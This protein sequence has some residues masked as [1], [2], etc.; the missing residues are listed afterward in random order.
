M[1]K[2]RRLKRE[3][4]RRREIE[5]IKRRKIGYYFHIHINLNLYSMLQK[6]ENSK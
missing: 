4:I 2:E 6:K 5:K 3:K 1:R